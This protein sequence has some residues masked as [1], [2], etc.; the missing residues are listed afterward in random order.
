VVLSRWRY[1]IARGR[2]RRRDTSSGSG[3]F[4]R[5]GRT[6]GRQRGIN[7]PLSSTWGL[8]GSGFNLVT[9]HPWT[10]HFTF[11]ILVSFTLRSFATIIRGFAGDSGERV[12]IISRI[13]V[14]VL[15]HFTFSIAFLILDGDAWPQGLAIRNR[16]IGDTTARFSLTNVLADTYLNALVSK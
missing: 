8:V 6:P 3:T 14:V 10:F 9:V 5:S 15:S 1:W 13:I 2:R 16:E 12:V 11:A 4:V 7:S